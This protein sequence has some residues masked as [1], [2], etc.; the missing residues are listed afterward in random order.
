[1]V[2]RVVASIFPV[3]AMA[4]CVAL[5]FID[6]QEFATLVNRG[7]CQEAN[8]MI[9][10]STFHSAADRWSYMGHLEYFCYKNREAGLEL[11]NRAAS[12]GDRWAMTTL[13]KVGER[14]PQNVSSGAGG[15]PRTAIDVYIHK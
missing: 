9:A 13:A 5:G 6:D 8:T 10:R 7:K 11:L 1:M 4:G 14:L 2:N 3:M 15:V 12:R